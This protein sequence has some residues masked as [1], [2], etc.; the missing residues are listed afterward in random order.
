MNKFLCKYFGHKESSHVYYG[1]PVPDQSGTTT[2][3][4]FHCERCLTV[5][6]ER[7][8]KVFANSDPVT[9]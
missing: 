5:V 2:I 9:K 7:C 1:V 3:C 8:I 4:E 6:T